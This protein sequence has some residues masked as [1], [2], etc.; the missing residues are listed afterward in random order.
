MSWNYRRIK[1]EGVDDYIIVGEVYYDDD[2]HPCGWCKASIGG[3]TEEELEC[4]LKM[5][6][7]DMKQPILILPN[8][9]LA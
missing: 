2:G 4:N 5:I 1:F 6:I 7:E 8:S 3:E 9:Y